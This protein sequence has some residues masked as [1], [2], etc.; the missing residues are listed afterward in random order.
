[1]AGIRPQT[2]PGLHHKPCGNRRLFQSRFTR[3]VS[4]ST[5]SV[6]ESVAKPMVSTQRVLHAQRDDSDASSSN[7]DAFDPEQ[8]S[9]PRRFPI[10]EDV[11]GG[12]VEDTDEDIELPSDGDEDQH[13]MDEDIRKISFGALASAQDSLHGQHSGRPRPKDA[14]ASS[15]RTD[16]DKVNTLRERLAELKALK[17]RRSNNPSVSPHKTARKSSPSPD[18]DPAT[19]ATRASKHAPTVQTSKRQVTR[20]RAV[21]EVAKDPT[22]ARDPRFLPGHTTAATLPA[23]EAARVKHNYAF[24]S[25]FRA[26]EIA[27]LRR[28]LDALNA[29]AKKRRSGALTGAEEAEKARLRRVIEVEENRQRAER[30]RRRLEDVVREHRKTEREAVKMGKKP[31]FLKK[32]EIK[33]KVLEERWKGMKGKERE[34][35]VKKRKKKLSERE[36]RAMPADRR[37][38]G[39]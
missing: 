4:I 22:H 21:I 5:K 20:R 2:L 12:E 14:P 19:A 7:S 27:E 33:K 16:A 13:S 3:S 18:P 10:D 1:M 25:D 15:T 11:D 8:E 39:Q 37:V 26:T 23:S 38:Q 31:F 24:L 28:T 32:G 6:T 34:K 9:R 17:S 36:R 30:E 29:G 35:A